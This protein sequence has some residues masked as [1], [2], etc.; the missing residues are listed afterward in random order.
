MAWVAKTGDLTIR[1][2][3]QDKQDR[4]RPHFARCDVELDPAG[5]ANP[6]LEC[7]AVCRASWDEQRPMRARRAGAAAKLPRCTCAKCGSVHIVGR[8]T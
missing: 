8:D 5:N 1:H 6:D 3:L 7:C 4:N 2:I